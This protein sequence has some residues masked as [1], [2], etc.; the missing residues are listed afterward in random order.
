MIAIRNTIINVLFVDN[1]I[2]ETVKKPTGQSC[3]EIVG[4]M[5]LF[6]GFAQ[7]V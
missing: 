5:K 6:T 1:D 7:I 3:Q 2:N 4:G